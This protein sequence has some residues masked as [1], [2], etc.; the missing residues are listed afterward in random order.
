MIKHIVMWTFADEA[1]G[2]PRAENVAEAKRLLEGCAGVVPGMGAF[3]VAPAQEG[4]EASY[5]LCLYS[6]FESVAALRAYVV[7]PVHQEVAGF[8]RQVVT[9]RVAFDFDDAGLAP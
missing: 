2:R 9:T 8:I 5:D 7:H 6:E 1:L 3:Q 4:L